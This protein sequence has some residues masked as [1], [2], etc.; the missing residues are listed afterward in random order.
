MTCVRECDVDLLPNN[1]KP[2]VFPGSLES[3]VA[4][5]FTAAPP[6][7]K[8]SSTIILSGFERHSKLDFSLILLLKQPHGSSQR[9]RGD[10]LLYCLANGGQWSHD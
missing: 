2:T 5:S 3:R 9:S 4:P 7:W 8:P 6:D 1:V 10:R